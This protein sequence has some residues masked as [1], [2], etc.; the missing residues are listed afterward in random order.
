M[1]KEYKELFDKCSTEEQVYEVINSFSS[2]TGMW[3]TEKE[4][5]Y[6][7]RVY[8]HFCE[9]NDWFEETKLVYLADMTEPE[10]DCSPT[11]KQEDDDLI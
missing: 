3:F 6:L 4:D 10:D 5:K 9:G 11:A 2:D 8:H 1:K 7:M